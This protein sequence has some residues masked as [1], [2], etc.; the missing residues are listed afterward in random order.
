[1]ESDRFKK[2][3]GWNRFAIQLR[4]YGDFEAIEEAKKALNIQIE[5]LQYRLFDGETPEHVAFQFEDEPDELCAWAY[6]HSEMSLEDMDSEILVVSEDF[7]GYMAFYDFDNQLL[8]A[9][10]TGEYDTGMFSQPEGRAEYEEYLLST[11]N[12][13]EETYRFPLLME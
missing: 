10:D 2:K 8:Q 11:L 4:A 5:E 9:Y 13:P 1:M 7:E 12:N 6:F 3:E